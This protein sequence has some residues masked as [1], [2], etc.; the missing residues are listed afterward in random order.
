MTIT[1]Q[2]K[3][4]GLVIRLQRNHQDGNTSAASVTKSEIRKHCRENGLPLPEGVPDTSSPKADETRPASAPAGG[5]IMELLQV[6]AEK[7]DLREQLNRTRA[8]LEA[9]QRMAN[10]K[11]EIAERYDQFLSALEELFPEAEDRPALLESISDYRKS[12]D[13]AIAR[14]Q[15]ME[16][17][18]AAH[19][20]FD[21]N[22]DDHTNALVESLQAQLSASRQA[23]EVASGRVMD[24]EAELAREADQRSGQCAPAL[25]PGVYAADEVHAFA[26]GFRGAGLLLALCPDALSSEALNDIGQ[27]LLTQAHALSCYGDSLAPQQEDNDAA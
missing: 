19:R 20:S 10:D 24:L 12:G 6:T 3:L 11:S 2:E 9:S 26:A 27:L 16:A 23:C 17:E 7:D 15:E 13:A 18:M 1:A 14:V 21:R 4:N 5:G 8:E 22:L 25:G